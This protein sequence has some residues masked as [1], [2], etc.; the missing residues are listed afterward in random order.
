MIFTVNRAV[1]VKLLK[2]VVGN[3]AVD[4]HEVLRLEAHNMLLKIS[5]DRAG[6]E[7]AAIITK[8]GVA[9]I[10][11]YKFLSLMRSFKGKKSLTLEITPEGLRVSNFRISADIWVAIFDNPATAP[12]QIGTDALKEAGLH[13]SD[14]LLTMADLPRWRQKL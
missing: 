4:D 3:P 5:T 2:L 10:R 13:P 9:F 11:A 7:C 8:K 14:D 6:A 1:F 12:S